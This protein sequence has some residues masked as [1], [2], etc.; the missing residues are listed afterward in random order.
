MARIA[1]QDNGVTFEATLLEASSP[2]C[3]VLF[4]VGSGGNPE[5]HLP[6]LHYL[7]ENHC[8]VIAP[9][10]DRL[11]SPSPS[12][13]DLLL[14]ARRLQIALDFGRE[15]DPTHPQDKHRW[16]EAPSVAE[17]GLVEQSL[18]HQERTAALH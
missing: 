15:D 5:R 17:V 14:R 12:A 1:L 10:F 13:A 8:T 4:A 2:V 16:A 6:L 3:K 18:P 7:F 11:V 9:H